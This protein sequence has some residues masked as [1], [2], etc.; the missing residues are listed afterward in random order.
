MK[1]YYL[2][3]QQYGTN[4]PL[5]SNCNAITFINVGATDCY[6]NKFLL[7]SGASLSITGNENEI[8]VTTYEMY[9]TTGIGNL[10]VIRKFFK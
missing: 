4:T 1:K 3:F 5:A 7:A 2:D 9:F 10:N 6:I 8:D